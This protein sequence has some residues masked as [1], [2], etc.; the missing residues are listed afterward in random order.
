MFNLYPGCVPPTQ[1]VSPSAFTGQGRTLSWELTTFLRSHPKPQK[2]RGQ[3]TAPAWW[4]LDFS[5]R[6]ALLLSTKLTTITW[7]TISLSQKVS[8]VI[9]V[10][11]HLI[12]QRTSNQPCCLPAPREQPASRDIRTPQGPRTRSAPS[13]NQGGS[14]DP[15]EVLSPG[16]WQHLAALITLPNHHW[17]KS[18]QEGP[19]E[20]PRPKDPL[21]LMRRLRPKGWSPLF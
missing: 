14:E 1:R 10:S 15:W 18:E 11:L 9:S 8:I 13:P 2:P 7:G 16:K 4:F 19:Q 17:W 20:S 12:S 3:Q 6:Q 21:I 5:S